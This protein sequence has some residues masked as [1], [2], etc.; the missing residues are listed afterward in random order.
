MKRCPF[1]AEDIQDA[2]VYCRY[3]RLWLEPRGD[4]DGAGE[5]EITD[6]R[7]KKIAIKLGAGM[8][9]VAL[10][11]A[12]AWAGVEQGKARVFGSRRRR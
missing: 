6:G 3:C 9:Y 8:G 1:C 2:A 7:G 4:G 5:V 10:A 11:A 12:S